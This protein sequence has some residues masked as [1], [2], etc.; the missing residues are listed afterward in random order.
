MKFRRG[1]QIRLLRNVEEYFPALER[2]I[3]AAA[4]EIFLEIF[5]HRDASS[6]FQSVPGPNSKFEGGW[7]GAFGR[8]PSWQPPAGSLPVRA[9]NVL[10]RIEGDAVRI[11][12]SV[13]VGKKA[14]D[15]EEPVATYLVRE[16][17]RSPS[18]S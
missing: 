15:K 5:C 6:D 17:K 16:M 11:N 2:E 8:I 14:M 4:S 10:S 18:M 12:V 13:F 9:V 7:F 3:E 1:N